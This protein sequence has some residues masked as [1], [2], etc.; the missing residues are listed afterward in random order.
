MTVRG[1]QTPFQAEG[2]RRDVQKA[3]NLINHPPEMP[4]HSFK[5]NIDKNKL[6]PN[7]NDCTLQKA[8]NK[9]TVVLKDWD[10]KPSDFVLDVS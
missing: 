8:T 4:D 6:G 7:D 5:P 9:L 1:G 3:K 2:E 10:L